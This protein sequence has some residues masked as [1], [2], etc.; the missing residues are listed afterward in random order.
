[1]GASENGWINPMKNPNNMVILMGN[2]RILHI[3]ILCEPWNA[4]KPSAGCIGDLL[5][6]RR[7]WIFDGTSFLVSHFSYICYLLG[8]FNMFQTWMDYFPFHMGYIILP[9]DELI[10]FRGVGIPPT[11]LLLI[12]INHMP[13]NNHIITC[14]GWSSVHL[15]TA[16]FPVRGSPPSGDPLV[17]YVN[18]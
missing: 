4:L 9:I 13:Y 2:M 6:R 3:W 7:W 5:L 14:K 11:R 15:R 18:T 10:F 16:W 12:I 8:G 1:M 17:G